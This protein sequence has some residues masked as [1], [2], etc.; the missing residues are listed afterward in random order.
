MR[1]SDWRVSAATCALAALISAPLASLADA[2]DDYVNATLS[3]D[4]TPGL[5]L[6]V[7][8]NGTLLRAQGYGYANLEHRV[9]VHPDTIF[10]S[11]SLG[12]MFTAVAVM[13]LVEDGKLQLDTAIRSYLPEAPSSWQGITLRQVLNHTSGLG[14]SPG[15]D[16]RKDYSDEELLRMVYGVKL[17]FS[18]GQRMSYSNAGYMLLGL[19]VKQVGGQSYSDLLKARVFGPLGM[20]TAG[21]IDDRGIVANRAASY[22]VSNDGTLRNAEW[23]SPTGNSTADGA[24]YLTVLDWAKWDAAVRAGKILK[25]Q[26]WAEI[27]RPARLSSGKT[28]PYGFGWYLSSFAGKQVHYHSGGWQGFMT[29]YVSYEDQGLSVIVLTNGSNGKAEMVARQVAQ[30]INPQLTPPAGAPIDDRDPKVTQR[31]SKILRE[32][33]LPAGEQSAFA[34]SDTFTRA[35]AAYKRNRGSLGKLRELRLFAFEEQGDDGIYSYR[36]RFDKELAEVTFGVSPGGV[37]QRLGVRPLASWNA[38]LKQ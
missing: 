14:R 15:L 26:S 27:F 1:L 32:T 2:V 28:Y 36:A 33:D 13:L 25:A 12:K 5:A 22:E 29:F 31:L 7:V 35:A 30:M 38:P 34:S 23:I 3:N 16:L 17:D 19:L 20:H 9:P 21:L 37:I 11:A 6:A 8:K 24:L 10:Q 4:H 18:P